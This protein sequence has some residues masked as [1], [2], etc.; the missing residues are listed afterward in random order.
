[1]YW[2]TLDLSVVVVLEGIAVRN[3]AKGHIDERA[4]D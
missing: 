4:S 2:L 1:M 3:C